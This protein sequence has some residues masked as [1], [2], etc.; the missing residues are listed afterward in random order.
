MVKKAEQQEYF[1]I[2]DISEILQITYRTAYGYCHQCLTCD[3]LRGLCTC[4]GEPRTVFTP[5]NVSINSG[6]NGKTW[7]INRKQVDKFL[8]DRRY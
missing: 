3:R 7:R 5:I 4:K 8:K 1:S 6:K 2:A